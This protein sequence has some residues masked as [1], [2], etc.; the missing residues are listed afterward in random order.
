MGF[1]DDDRVIVREVAVLE[2]SISQT[3]QIK[4][5]EN[6]VIIEQTQGKVKDNSTSSSDEHTNIEKASKPSS[7][8]NISIT[9]QKNSRFGAI[10]SYA[11][12]LSGGLRK[13]GSVFRTKTKEDPPKTENVNV[14]AKIE[15]SESSNISKE[16]IEPK[17]VGVDQSTKSSSN[18]KPE[19]PGLLF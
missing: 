13:V 16:N 17:I 15:Y 14:D 2:P 3:V 4:K 5:T 6:E 7:D 8:D 9:S 12:I 18:D 11:N 19:I 10:K 1:S